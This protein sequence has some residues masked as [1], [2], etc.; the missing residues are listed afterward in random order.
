MQ[1][2][3]LSYLGVLATFVCCIAG[4]PASGYP[5][6][7]VP[8][9]ELIEQS[10]TI[11][12]ADV[13]EVREVEIADRSNPPRDTAIA[14]LRVRETWKGRHIDDIQVPFPS[15][16]LCPAP[17]R[18]AKG[19]VVIAFLTSDDNATFQTVALSYGTLYPRREEV[20]DYHLRIL[21][22]VGLQDRAASETA[23]LDWL[24]R[25][26][27]LRSMRWHGLYQLAGGSD[28]LHSFYD[29]SGVGRSLASRL[30]P[31]Q[32][33]RIADG[34]VA[35]PSLDRTLPMILTVLAG[36]KSRDVDLA[37][38]S[39]IEALLAQKEVPWWFSDPLRLTLARFGD[40]ASNTHVAP[41][42][43]DFEEV[44]PARARQVWSEARRTLKI[45]KVAPAVAPDVE[46][47]GVGPNTP[48]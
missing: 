24:V 41:L 7:P 48:S 29:R 35:E 2:R 25:V 5:I 17:P 34:F 33:G 47:W 28:K 32:L 20:E 39:A 44:D 38:A 42:G 12:L 9:W 45:P 6:R 11:V 21:E 13:H 3:S 16:L 4:V 36:L 26:A 1:H 31:L 40:P 37:A 27:S 19:K 10:Q 30:S 22:A 46:V 18:Y 8:L 23:I 15:N 14:Q 43:G